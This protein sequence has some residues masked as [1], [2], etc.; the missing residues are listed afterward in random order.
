MK[1]GDTKP[2]D[3]ARSSLSIRTTIGQVLKLHPRAGAVFERHGMSCAK[4][5]GANAEPIEKA[6]E[7]YGV[8]PHEIVQELKKLLS[9]G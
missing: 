4:C 9:G 3:A 7:M 5:G 8:N 1:K 2:A 6:A